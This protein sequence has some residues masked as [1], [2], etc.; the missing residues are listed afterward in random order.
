MTAR[1][2]IRACRKKPLRAVQVVELSERDLPHN[3]DAEKS[4]LGAL[5]VDCEAAQGV[6]GILGPDDFYSDRHKRTFDAAS[7]L[8]STHQSLDQILLSEE[9]KNRGEAESTGGIDYLD[10]LEDFMPAAGNAE[11]YA[12]IIKDKA[13]LRGLHETCASIVSQIYESSQ[14][15]KEQQ[16]AAESALFN[17]GETAAAR[18]DFSPIKDDVMLVLDN[19]DKESDL[20]FKTG[21]TDLDDLLIGL[22]PSQ[23]VIIAGRPSMGKTSFC[24]NVIRNIAEGLGGEASA[25]KVGIFSLEVSSLDLVTNLLC[26]SAGVDSQRVRGKKLSPEDHGKI[27][28][29]A[30]RLYQKKIFIDDTPGLTVLQLRT[31]ARRLHRKEKLDLIVID[32]LQLMEGTSNE[33][34]QQEISAISRGLKGIARELKVPVI[35]VS[36]LSRK[37]EDRESKRP[38]LAD[39]RESGAIEQDADL[40]LMLHRP[41]YYLEGGSEQKEKVKNDATVLLLKNRN[42]PTGDVSLHFIKHLLRF[43]NRSWRNDG[44]DYAPSEEAPE[45]AEATSQT[46]DKG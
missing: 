7:H 30:G 45:L 6:F 26:I 9:I 8:H 24:L 46:A 21:Y 25:K 33:S 1:R 2:T 40:V 42:G 20:G 19:L 4:V 43:Q 35:A 37:V 31:R 27:T 41:E 18:A 3:I 17:L 44:D 36:Q 14:S 23:F 15:A 22:M 28:E 5:L 39:L 38:R 10:E 16:D 32:Y 13:I 12:K 11:Y 29:A 34:R